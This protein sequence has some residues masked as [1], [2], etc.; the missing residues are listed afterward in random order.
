M[1]Y[2]A[3]LEIVLKSALQ[4][5]DLNASTH[6]SHSNS[7][8]ND[9]EE[10]LAWLVSE[11]DLPVTEGEVDHHDLRNAVVISEDV[12][13]ANFASI[14]QYALLGVDRHSQRNMY[15]NTNIPSSAYICGLQ[16][17]GKSHTLSCLLENALIQSP[18]LGKLS[19]P[20]SGVVLHY[21]QFTSAQYFH[22]CEA[23][24]LSIPSP[25]FPG[26]GSPVKVTV[27]VSPSNFHSLSASYSQIPGI[28]IRKLLLKPE[29]LS[30]STML[31]LMA[32]S[33]SSGGN[34]LYMAQVTKVLRAMA[35][36]G[37]KFDY[38]EFKKR[39]VALKLAFDQFQFL[40]QRLSLLE[41]FLDLKGACKDED[42]AFPKGSLTIV[43][44][45]CPFVDDNMAC[46]LFDIFLKVYFETSAAESC[47][48]IVALDEAHRYLT[49]TPASKLLT[50][51][52]LGLIRQQRHFGARIIISSQE[53]TLDPRLLDLSSMLIFHRFSSPEW[54]SALS[55]HVPL[56]D[57]GNGKMLLDRVLKLRTGEAIVFVPSGILGGEEDGLRKAC[58]ELV[59]MKVRKR[60]TWDGGHSI[61]A[62]E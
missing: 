58:D 19:E 39:L 44:L 22:P 61:V 48:K 45:S 40:E 11:A 55:K 28:T 38:H 60:V 41:S 25:E 33:S 9:K 52:L 13:D 32:V 49:N 8:I 4:N 10:A 31:Q 57:N 7:L 21:S 34:T 23:A 17:S 27:Y 36:S 6:E 62:V 20:L 26:R 5:L 2:E 50:T 46:L 29:Q 53:P 59:T 47:G 1:F 37:A 15:L 30:I 18:A 54:A 43:D 51:S 16:G 14:P 12:L 56:S 3:N 35:E 42:F 24:F